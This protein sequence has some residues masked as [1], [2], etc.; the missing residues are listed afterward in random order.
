MYDGSVYSSDY[1]AFRWPGD[2]ITGYLSTAMDRF[3]FRGISLEDLNLAHPPIFNAPVVPFYAYFERLQSVADV[4]IDDDGGRLMSRMLLNGSYYEIRQYTL[5]LPYDEERADLIAHGRLDD[6]Y[7]TVI[8][9]NGQLEISGVLDVPLIVC[10]SGNIWLIDDI[11]Y[12]GADE[13]TGA[14]DENETNGLLGLESDGDIIIANTPANGKD[15]GWNDGADPEATD[16]HSIIINAALSIPKGSLKFENPNDDADFYQ[17]PEPDERG[18]IHLKGAIAQQRSY[19][20]HNAN[21]SG[22]GYKIDFHYDNRLDEHHLYYLDLPW[23]FTLG[24]YLESYDIGLGIVVNDASC[25][26]FYAGYNAELRFLHSYTVE[27]Y[28]RLWFWGSTSER[29]KV[30]YPEWS[31]GDSAAHII[32]QLDDQ[33]P[34]V[35]M[36]NTVVEPGVDIHFFADTI[37]IDSCSFAGNVYLRAAYVS[38]SHSVFKDDVTVTGWKYPVFD[39]NVVEGML[40]IDGNPRRAEVTNNTIIN[41]GGVGVMLATYRRAE[42]RNNIIYSCDRG[43]VNDHWETPM[44]E[45]NDVYGNGEDYTDCQ[46]GDG[47]I[48]LDPLFVSPDSG[49]FHLTWNS[50]CIDAGDPDSPP[51]PDGTCADI[52]AFY[53]DALA[54]PSSLIPLPSSLN[55]SVYPN[56]F[57]A[58]AVT[59]YKLQVTSRVNLALYDINGRLV[60][61]LVDGSRSAG[62]HQAMIDGANLPAGEY[63]IKLEAGERVEVNKIVYL[64]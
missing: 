51:D 20:L 39:H 34:W 27:V 42:L 64:R 8:F 10:A 7:S 15:N 2:T 52:G 33:L 40:T 9:F 24:G 4:E 54:I 23:I 46:P 50:P 6:Y 32:V 47:S 58:T 16:A 48:S 45:Y 38:V 19:S 22:T 14:F 44:L 62:R 37:R 18:I 3:L 35:K 25:K 17:G 43:V 61:T 11:R 30:T 26:Y 57:N 28:H 12:E 13:I 53:F 63:L 29:A 55:M 5:G 31:P 59:S 56:P 49:D 41:P 60:Q 21:H 1:F 36:I